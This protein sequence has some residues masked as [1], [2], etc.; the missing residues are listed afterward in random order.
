[1]DVRREAEPLREW[2]EAA[3]LAMMRESESPYREYR[4]LVETSDPAIM[5]G[6][7]DIASTSGENV[8]GR[9]G[10]EGRLEVSLEAELALL[11]SMFWL[12]RLMMKYA[13][14]RIMRSITTAPPII[15]PI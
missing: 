1:M 13:T 15:P 5:R 12:R 2:L 11:I 6:S 7:T 4:L 14:T 9:R 10:P 3:E 8:P